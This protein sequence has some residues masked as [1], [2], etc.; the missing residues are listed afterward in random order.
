MKFVYT[1]ITSALVLLGTVGIPAQ[2]STNTTDPRDTRPDYV[3]H[4]D[5]DRARQN[6]QV[7]RIVNDSQTIVIGGRGR[8]GPLSKE[9]R[10]QIEEE[11]LKTVE[12]INRILA[13]PPEYGVRHAEFLKGKNT[14]LARLVPD[15]G[16]DKG[17]VV[18]VQELERC[19]DTAQIRG[20]GSRYSFRLNNVPSNLPLSAIHW[21][22]AISDIHF[23]DG[24]IVV[25]SKEIL[26]IISDIGD[27]QLTEVDLKS[28]SLKFLRSFDP[29]DTREDI[30]QQRKEL[31][32]GI[33]EN[34]F[35]YSTSANAVVNRTYVLRS[36]NFA[37]PR[38]LNFWNTDQ[39]VAFRI[40]GQ[41][42]DGSVVLL[43][44]QLK[45]KKGHVLRSW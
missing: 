11:K 17:K 40:V 20:A 9:R 14:G 32:A 33:T 29:D 7:E 19:S 43:W 31:T 26:D 37:G 6:A 4:T 15:R 30:E 13:T 45:E 42:K 1:S 22:V 25:G 34:G 12:E 39:I 44:K 16:C 21:L 28:P 27:V 35:A 8:T 3:R 5:A 23:V 18:T 36:I 24:N 38:F 41:E 2:T 10:R